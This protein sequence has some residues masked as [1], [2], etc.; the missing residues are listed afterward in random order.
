MAPL[1][2]IKRYKM[3]I[4][5]AIPKDHA[6]ICILYDIEKSQNMYI[7]MAIKPIFSL[8]N[9]LAIKK[10]KI[11]QI[12]FGKLTAINI[13]NLLDTPQMREAIAEYTCIIVK[14]EYFPKNSHVPV[15][16]MSTI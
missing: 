2:P 4:Y 5:S 13:P 15:L 12:I 6:H 16:I 8:N 11:L 3:I 7:S 14:L 9:L 1:V 10:I